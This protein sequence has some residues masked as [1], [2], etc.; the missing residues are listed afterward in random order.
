[1]TDDELARLEAV[2]RAA[3]E[4]TG[5]W[6]APS[7]LLETEADSHIPITARNGDDVCDVLLSGLPAEYAMINA[8][9]IATFGPPT[10]LALLAEVR[11]L[12]TLLAEI[13]G[14]WYV[15]ERYCIF[16]TSSTI[17]EDLQELAQ[18]LRE[19][20]QDAGIAF[21]LPDWVPHP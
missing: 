5:A 4:M 18:Q 14:E 9:H 20:E 12:R 7:P 21:N 15:A 1:M 6:G 3:N 17:Q 8:A 10:V 11:R 16:E 2:A 13:G 19:R